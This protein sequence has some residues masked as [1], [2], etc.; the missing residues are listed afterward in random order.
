MLAHLLNS[1]LNKRSESKFKMDDL[2]LSPWSPVQTVESTPSLNAIHL[3]TD[4]I[5]GKEFEGLF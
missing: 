3:L 1:S 5:A 2:H 4:H